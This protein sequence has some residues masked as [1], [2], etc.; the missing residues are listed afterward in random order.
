MNIL[1]DGCIYI[2]EKDED[3]KICNFSPCIKDVKCYDKEGSTEYEVT[4]FLQYPNGTTSK[5][6]CLTL[7][8]I[9]T[10]DWESF[11]INATIFVSKAKAGSVIYKLIREQIQNSPPASVPYFDNLGW[12]TYKNEPAYVAGSTVITASRIL[13]PSEY[14]ISQDL[15]NFNFDFNPRVNKKKGLSLFLRLIKFRRQFTC[16]RNDLNYIAIASIF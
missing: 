14:Y 2:K 8:R 4:F 5:P 6:I 9:L 11:D 3:V 16:I 7:N 13:N 15:Q 1:R 10:F 12:T